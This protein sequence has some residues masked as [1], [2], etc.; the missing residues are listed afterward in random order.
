M[1]E[2]EKIIEQIDIQIR[3]LLNI[4]ALFPAV[5]NEM[6]GQT[7]FSTAPF[8]QNKGLNIE[9]TLSSPITLEKI[10]EINEIGRWVNQS[11]VVRLCALL[12]SH[13]IISKNEKEKID[14]SI[15]GHEDV[16]ILRRLRNVLAHTSGRYNP[17]NSD[18]RKLYERMVERYSINIDGLETVKEFPLHID[19]FLLPLAES[20]KRYVI[21][22]G[23]S[24]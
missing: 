4:R 10:Q 9:F 23:S 7:K 15:D 18:E 3:N 13:H 12:E 5:E 21:G 16:D 11:F 8:Y 17:T 2:F 22:L 14:Q 24:S 6:V 20:C 19:T 1:S